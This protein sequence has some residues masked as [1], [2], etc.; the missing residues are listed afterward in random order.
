MDNLMQRM[1]T[2]S[3]EMRSQSWFNSLDDNQ[4]IKIHSVTCIVE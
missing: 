2:I 1:D 4:P 3:Q